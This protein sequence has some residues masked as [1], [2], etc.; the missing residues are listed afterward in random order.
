MPKFTVVFSP[1][2][3]I[4]QMRSAVSK[5]TPT[6]ETFIPAETFRFTSAWRNNPAS[7]ATLRQIMDNELKGTGG[8]VQTLTSP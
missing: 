5:A 3:T 4:N 1:G 7:I 8:S 6:V 2:L